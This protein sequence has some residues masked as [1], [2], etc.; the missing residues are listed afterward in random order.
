MSG[1]LGRLTLGKAVPGGK[2]GGWVDLAGSHNW[3]VLW[4]HRHGVQGRMLW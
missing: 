1:A 3:R 2:L 4:S